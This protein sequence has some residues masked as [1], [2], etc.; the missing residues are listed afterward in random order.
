LFDAIEF[1][2]HGAVSLCELEGVGQVVEEHLLESL[3][4]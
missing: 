3:L 1:D 2:P 4:V